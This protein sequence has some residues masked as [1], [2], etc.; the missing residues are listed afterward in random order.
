MKWALAGAVVVLL[1]LPAV[2]S[3]YALTLFIL[4]FFYGFLGQSWNIVGGY[5]GQ[6]SAG[7]AAFVGVGGYTAT[8]L[9]IELGLTEEQKRQIVPILEQE[10][11]QLGAL[12]K[13]TSLS[14]LK[15]V[16]LRWRQSTRNTG[17]PAASVTLLR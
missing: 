4:I 14:A 13:D 2:L 3:P 5:A 16:E 8:M 6:L 9:S 10:L 7:H 17:L 1:A 15:K 11:K 12:K